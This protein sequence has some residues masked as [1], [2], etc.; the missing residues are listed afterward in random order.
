MRGTRTARY[1]SVGAASIQ[2]AGPLP[3]E[4]CSDLVMG[5]G[6]VGNP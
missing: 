4:G 6:V 3:S 5:V 1:P 2:R